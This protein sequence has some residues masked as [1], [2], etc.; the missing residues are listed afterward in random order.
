MTK[1]ASIHPGGKKILLGYGK[2]ATELFMKYHSW[3]NADAIIGKC[4]IGMLE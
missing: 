3:V 2:D 1:Y 4:F